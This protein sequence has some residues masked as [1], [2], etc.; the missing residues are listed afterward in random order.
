MIEYNSTDEDLGVH[1]AFD[2]HGWSELSVFDPKTIWW[3]MTHDVRGRRHPDFYLAANDV[4]KAGDERANP[5]LCERCIGSLSATAGRRQSAGP[6]ARG[7]QALGTRRPDGTPVTS[8][9]A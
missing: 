8:G 6:P 5:F 2:D 3:I 4:S 9:D 7:L 1:G